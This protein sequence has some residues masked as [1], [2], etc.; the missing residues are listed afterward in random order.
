M[1]MTGRDE[2]QIQ[3]GERVSASAKDVRH[4]RKRGGRIQKVLE[5]DL[6][7]IKPC[8]SGPK[9]P[10]DRIDLPDLKKK[11]NQLFTVAGR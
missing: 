2:K 6:K 3:T 8:V 1:R 9:R 4:P 10:Q 5:L 7:S 11:F